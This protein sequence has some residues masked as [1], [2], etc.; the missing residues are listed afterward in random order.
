MRWWW[1]TDIHFLKLYR[2]RGG[3]FFIVQKGRVCEK[4]G[5]MGGLC[6]NDIESTGIFAE[7]MSEHHVTAARSELME[8]AKALQVL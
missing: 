3:V 7:K 8:G 1:K 2:V 4:N 6:R 5:K